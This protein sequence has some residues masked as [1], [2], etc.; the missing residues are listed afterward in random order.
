MNEGIPKQFRRSVLLKCLNVLISHI[1]G[2]KIVLKSD[3]K[4]DD[5]GFWN[6]VS[7]P[8]ICVVL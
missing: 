3:P 6:D 7:L 8:A 2:K 5:S 4:N 1:V